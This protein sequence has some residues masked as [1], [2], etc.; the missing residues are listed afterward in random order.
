MALTDTTAADLEACLRDLFPLH[1]SITGAGNRDTLRRLQRLI[2]LTIH[3]VPSGRQVYDWTVP[4]EWT[5]RNAWIAAPDGTRVVDLATHNLH[6]VSY[7]EPVSARLTWEQLAGHVHRHPTLPEAIPY[8]TS[9]YSR[10]WGFCVTAAQ[11]DTL[12]AGGPWDVHIDSSLEPG[13]LTYGELLIAGRSQAEILV[14]C[15]ICHPSMA[16]DSLSGV[17]LTAFLAAARMQQQTR[18]YSWRVVFVPE[19][20]GAITYA[21]LN[22][23][24]MKKIDLGVVITTAGG[25]GPLGY[26]QSFDPAHGVNWHVQRVLEETGEPFKVYPFDIHGSDERQYSSQ[27]FRINVATICKDRYYEYPEYHTSLDDLSFVNGGQL[28]QTFRAYECL[29]ARLDARRI[30]RSV[31][32]GC[33]VMLGPRG[34]YPAAGGTLRPETEGRSTLDLILWLLFYC[35][36][37]TA[38]DDIERRLHVPSGSLDDL[39]ALLS[40]KG[41][42]DRV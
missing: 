14:S 3:E 27:L 17:V 8:R 12:A 9:Y 25:P 36:G 16:N 13:S 10:T 30:Y 41:L 18:E 22:E 39:V 26:K 7:S 34:L 28:L 29:F 20:I 15:Y 32:P 2:P 24:A 33:E 42:L 40:E 19:T 4:P 31:Q 23:G 6:L 21:A 38:I 11:Y 1:R 37:R 5:V 35:D